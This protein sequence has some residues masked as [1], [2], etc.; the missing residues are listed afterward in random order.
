VHAGKHLYTLFAPQTQLPC[1]L[2]S[3]W[4]WL[5]LPVP[6]LA[7]TSAASGPCK[8]QGCL[9]NHQARSTMTG[10]CEGRTV[11]HTACTITNY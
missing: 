1:P 7:V 4:V 8:G 6:L 5:Q 3:P 2:T 9:A 11:L 10:A